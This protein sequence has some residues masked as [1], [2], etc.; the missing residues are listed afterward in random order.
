[1]AARTDRKPSLLEDEEL[2]QTV[3]GE[4]I[5]EVVPVA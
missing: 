5:L 3:A 1:M 4:K 2:K